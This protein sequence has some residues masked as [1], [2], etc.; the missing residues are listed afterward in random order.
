MNT[1]QQIYDSEINFELRSHWGTG[2][3]WKLGDHLN[4]YHASGHADSVKGAAEALAKAACEHFPTS[5][6]TQARKRI[7]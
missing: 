1:L 2:F 5:T 3:E 6:F 4:G 7:A